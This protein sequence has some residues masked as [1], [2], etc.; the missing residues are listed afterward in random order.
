MLT[1]NFA[2]TGF[3]GQQTPPHDV[4][5]TLN[6]TEPSNLFLL[7]SGP[8]IGRKMY[9]FYLVFKEVLRIRKKRYL[10]L[11]MKNH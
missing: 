1:L 3:M 8:S 11:W 10:K 4:K 6:E 5:A 2:T 7:F 9:F